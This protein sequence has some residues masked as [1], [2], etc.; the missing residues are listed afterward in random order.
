MKS[1]CNDSKHLFP[2]TST[3]KGSSWLYSY[4]PHTEDFLLITSKLHPLEFL[5][6]LASPCFPNTPG[7]RSELYI[8]NLKIRKK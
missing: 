2:L 8:N 3:Y 5:L 4:A 6:G 7:Q 1:Q